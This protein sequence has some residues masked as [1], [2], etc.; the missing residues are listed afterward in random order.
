MINPRSE[1]IE[2]FKHHV[3]GGKYVKRYEK[4]LD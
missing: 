4:N 3:R 1:W 2:L